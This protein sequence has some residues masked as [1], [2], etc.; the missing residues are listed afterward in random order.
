[1]LFQVLGPVAARDA[2]GRAIELG[3]GKP[4]LVLAS[5]LLRAGDWV[6][7]DELID[8]TWAGRRPPPSAEANLKTYIWRLRRVLPAPAAGSRIE[9]RPG[10]YRI[11][12]ADAELDAGLAADLA[13]RA[14]DA[15]A[16]GNHGEAAVLAARG[17]E[18][19]R[20][21]PF[22]GVP[23]RDA[24]AARLAELGWSLRET[25]ARARLAGG[26]CSD[27][28]SALRA[29]TAEDPLRE[30]TWALLVEALAS[31]GRRGEALAAY[32][33][34][35]RVLVA[36][37]GVDP[38][39]ALV[40]AHERA[41]AGPAPSLPFGPRRELPRDVP[42][43]TGREAE[44]AE[45]GEVVSAPV[46]VA[47]VEGMPRVGKSALVVH[48]AHR[49]AGEFPD[50]QFHVDLRHGAASPAAVLDRLLRATGVDAPAVPADPGERAALWRSR[51]AGRRILL[52]LDDAADEAQ[53]APLLPAG[54]TALTLITTRTGDWHVPG[55]RRLRL[56]PLPAVAAEDLLRAGVADDRLGP[57]PVALRA[58][59]DL[60][61]GLP[62]LV[63]AAADRLAARPHWQLPDVVAWLDDEIGQG[64][65]CAAALA[66]SVRRLPVAERKVFALCSK[67]PVDPLRVSRRL[68]IGA[69]E[70]RRLLE[71]LVDHNLITVRVAGRYT[72]HPVLRRLAAGPPGGRGAHVA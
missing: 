58:L 17:L 71:R 70:A 30:G 47:L 32:S 29:L 51:I 7:V 63:R 21:R 27:A 42:G 48:L 13:G 39:P 44:L 38:G 14:E 35:R 65:G 9:H 56:A 57:D 54:D 28:V 46:R 69:P 10:A 50:G 49:L 19:W 31:A 2:D 3:P 23:G 45:L 20:G 16:A 59:L 12:V 6:S 4:V 24:A 52:V 11:R 67:G 64:S 34:A 53:I 36:E 25:L 26:R 1:V 43:F 60:C 18:L 22:E 72:V 66:S 40:A 8:T 62:G 37:L 68:R 41:L 55:A 61:A 15:L 5:L 33:D